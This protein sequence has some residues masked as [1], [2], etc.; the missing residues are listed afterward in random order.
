MV[1][2]AVTRGNHLTKVITSYII[3]EKEL[4]NEKSNETRLAVLSTAEC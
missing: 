2:G 1:I 4:K 3:K